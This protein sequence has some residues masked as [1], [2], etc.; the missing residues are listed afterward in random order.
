MGHTHS[1]FE[2]MLGNHN[3]TQVPNLGLTIVGLH[4]RVFLAQVWLLNHPE[5]L[6][7]L[8]N[9]EGKGVNLNQSH[10][11]GLSSLQY[12]LVF[13]EEPLSSIVIV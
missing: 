12:A 4:L 13:S 3:I 10:T 5:F 7:T 1:T 11:D 8:H 2:P 6:R 9:F